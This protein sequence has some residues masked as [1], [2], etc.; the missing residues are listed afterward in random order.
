[1]GYPCKYCG[2]LVYRENVPEE[3]EYC[4]QHQF[5]IQVYGRPLSDREAREALKQKEVKA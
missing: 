2:T 5:D 1:M 3:G 4:G